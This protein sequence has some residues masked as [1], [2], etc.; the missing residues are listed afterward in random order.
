MCGL[1]GYIYKIDKKIA[2]TSRIINMLKVQKHRGPDDTGIMAFNLFSK[3]LQEFSFENPEAIE[4]EFHGIFGFNRL[5]ILDI[6]KNG[7]QPM[8]NKEKNVIL[9]LNGEIYN[10][11]DF[12]KELESFGYNFKSTTDT[13]VILYLYIQYGLNGFLERLNGMFTIAIA[14]LRIGKTF[15]IR[16]RFGIKPLYYIDNEDILAFSSEIKSFEFLE[17]FCFQLNEE[18]LDEFLIFRNTINDSLFRDVYVLN[19]GN[20]IEYSNQRGTIIHNYFDVNS[21]QRRPKTEDIE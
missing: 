8:I 20:Y 10:A 7:H 21:Y 9:M 1:T 4:S 5:S 14:D 12:K 3:A 18:K 17:G 19:P 6:S 11:F 15:L 2:D 13:E 16:D